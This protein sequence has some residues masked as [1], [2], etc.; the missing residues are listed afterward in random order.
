MLE[1]KDINKVKDTVEEFFEKMTI[2]ASGIEVSSS[3]TEKNSQDV[4]STGSQV[5]A[6]IEE[7]PEGHLDVVDLNIK[8]DEPQILIGQ[9]GQT[10]LEIQRLLRTIL[11]KKLQKVFYLNLDINDYKKKKIEYLKDLAKDL[12]DQVSLTKEEKVLLP[13]SSY[14]RRIIHSEL[15]QRTDVITESQGEGFDRHIVIKLK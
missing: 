10:L 11:N 1:K 2:A 6:S 15:S 8:L 9:Q 14:E 7:R 12:A 13:M 5:K 4:A 3:S